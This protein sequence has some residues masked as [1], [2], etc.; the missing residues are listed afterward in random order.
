MIGDYHVLYCRNTDY[1]FV[2]PSNA[3]LQAQKKNFEKIGEDV[4]LRK[5]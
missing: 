2:Y 4:S 1:I 3:S 5:I